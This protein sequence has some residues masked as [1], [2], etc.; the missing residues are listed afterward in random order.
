MLKISTHPLNEGSQSF[1][2]GSVSIKRPGRLASVLRGHLG[3]GD[4]AIAAS[5]GSPFVRC[6][7][8]TRKLLG[9]L[10]TRV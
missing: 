2:E 4:N 5:R 7:A 3:R 10:P 8:A 6:H 1:E 9:V